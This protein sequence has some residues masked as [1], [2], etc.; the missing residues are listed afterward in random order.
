MAPYCMHD[1]RPICDPHT[2]VAFPVSDTSRRTAFE[3]K[4]T[5]Q[6]AIDI[7]II[8]STTSTVDDKIARVEENTK[9]DCV[10][11]LACR[12]IHCCSS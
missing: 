5:R 7:F 8:T 11:N 4:V 2:I 12:E 10:N 6:A 9:S 3:A 1:E